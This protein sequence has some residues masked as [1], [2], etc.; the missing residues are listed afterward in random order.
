MAAPDDDMIRGFLMA[1]ESAMDGCDR[2]SA[3][4]GQAVEA[5]RTNKPLAPS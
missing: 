1:L 3:L 5:Q 4:A 2:V